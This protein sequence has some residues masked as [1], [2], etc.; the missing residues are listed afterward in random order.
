M[1]STLR[2]ALMLSAIVLAVMGICAPFAMA[3]DAAEGIEKV[4]HNATTIGEG[5]RAAGIALAAAI[6]LAGAAFGTAR[7]QAAI[8]AGGTG[9][10]AEK[11]ELFMNVLILVALPETI[12]VLGFVIGF[13]ILGKI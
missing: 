5:I 10:M 4:N 6:A 1:N 8:G 12:V 9:A 2:K 11:P 3:A 7:A 13:L